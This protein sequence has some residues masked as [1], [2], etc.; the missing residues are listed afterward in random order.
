M[1]QCVSR[2][3]D[4]LGRMECNQWF[5]DEQGNCCEFGSGL[6]MTE[7]PKASVPHPDLPGLHAPVNE[8]VTRALEQPDFGKFR[9]KRLFRF[10]HLFSGPRD[11]IGDA[12]KELCDKEG[13]QLQVVSVDKVIGE[14]ADLMNDEPYGQMLHNAGKGHYDAGNAGFLCGSFSRARYNRSGFGPPPVRS[15]QWIYGLEGNTAKQQAEAGRGTVLAVRG[16]NIIGAILDSQRNRKV[17]RCGTLENPP[18]SKSQEEGPAWQVP[19][20]KKFL[21]TFNATVADYNT[22]AFQ[23]G[24]AVRWFKPGRLAGCLINLG[25]MAKT[26]RCESWVVHEAL[27]GK[28]KTVAAAEYTEQFGMEYAKLVVAS[29]KLTLQLE[30]WRHMVRVKASE[31]SQA[32]ISWLASKERSQDVAEGPSKRIWEISDPELD[33]RPGRDGPPPKKMRREQ[34][35]AHYVGGMRNPAISVSKLTRLKEVGMD[36]RR[37]WSH[38]VKDFPEVLDTARDYGSEHCYLEEKAKKEWTWALEGI[39]K[40]GE[41]Q[42]AVLKEPWEFTS[43]LNAKLWEA[44]FRCA[45]DPEEHLVDWIRRGT[46]LGMAEEVPCC[47]IFPPVEEADDMDLLPP[48]LEDQMHLGNYKSFTEEPEH[49]SIEIQRY[50]DKRLPSMCRMSGCWKSLEEGQ[51]PGWP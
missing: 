39:L 34:E 47:G 51:C 19:E 37:M 7:E 29:F 15:L 13:I 16:S 40:A 20:I 43:P 25:S 44:W 30:W 48:F 27:V 21:E 23:E 36:I 46:P 35:N 45:A 50:L 11:V 14:G 5:W 22:C 6:K 3:C 26:C 17:P 8:R 18:G 1:F 32:Q 42:D 4:L 33:T 41:F 28:A 38:F 49:A 2:R 24:M 9:S 12:L 31:V 10:L